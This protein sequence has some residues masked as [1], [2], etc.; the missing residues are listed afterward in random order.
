MEF[1]P[2]FTPQPSEKL[3]II[4]LIIYLIPFFAKLPWCFSDN[5]GLENE[6]QKHVEAE[7]RLGVAYLG[8]LGHFQAAKKKNILSGKTENT[9][10]VASR[11]LQ[12]PLYSN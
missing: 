2:F 8:R 1:V 5:L 9:R 12:R 10:I 3:Y 6:S 11:D 7:E 4:Q